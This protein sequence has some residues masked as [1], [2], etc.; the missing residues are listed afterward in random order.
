MELLQIEKTFNKDGKQMANI[1]GITPQNYADLKTDIKS[2]KVL[3][4]KKAIIIAN[5]F[6]LSLDKIYDIPTP[7]TNNLTPEET[8]LLKAFRVL[9]YEKLKKNIIED[10]H[11]AIELQNEIEQIK[12]KELN[13]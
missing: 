11:N 12:E 8:E 10:I 9:R 13:K 3:P 5:S 4:I 2:G 1:L 6:N 7:Q